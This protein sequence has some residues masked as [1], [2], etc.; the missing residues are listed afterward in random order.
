MT[1]SV[2]VGTRPEIIKM[3]PVYFALKKARMKPRLVHSGQHYDYQMSQVFFDELEL[4]K[5]DSFLGIGSGTPGKQTGEAIIKFEQEFVDHDADCVLVQGDTNTVLA[6]AVA[7]MKSGIKVGHVEAGLRSYDLRMPEE[8]NRRLTDHASDYLYA[9]TKDSVDILRKE[10]VWGK[11]YRTGNTVIDAAVMYLPKALKR[12]KVISQV[13]WGE[14]ALATLHRAE[15]CRRPED[16]EGPGRCAQGITSP[17]RAPVASEDRHAA[18]REWLE[19]GGR[20]LREHPTPSTSWLSGPIDPHETC[21][22]HTDRFRR[23]SGRGDLA[24]IEEE[25]VRDEAFH[26]APRSCEGGILHCGRD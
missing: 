13:P 19:G 9:P 8:L 12:S 20:I 14:F 10:H 16:I 21:F 3:A 17:C 11:V 6:A 25:G 23:H 26:G 22:V 15:N 18:Q 7:A 24:C 5:P 4:P 2:V 1:V